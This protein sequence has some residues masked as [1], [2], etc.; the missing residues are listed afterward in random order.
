MQMKRTEDTVIK[1][2]QKAADTSPQEKNENGSGNI[3]ENEPVQEPDKISPPLEEPDDI[4]PDK[5]ALQTILHNSKMA[6]NQN[7][8]G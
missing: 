5:K 7:T 2:L 1:A 4:E 8:Q 6:D 3:K